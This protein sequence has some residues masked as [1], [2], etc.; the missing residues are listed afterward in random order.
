MPFLLIWG[1]G[2]ALTSLAL[3]LSR[4]LWIRL[5]SDSKS[6]I[7]ALWGGDHKEMCSTDEM[8]FGFGFEKTFP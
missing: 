7:A 2:L 5:T 4:S 1:H 6:P 8:G 3:S